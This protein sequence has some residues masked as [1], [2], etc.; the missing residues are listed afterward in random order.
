VH[1]LGGK[2]GLGRR[3]VL[4]S[5][6][7]ARATLDRSGVVEILAHGHAQA[8][9]G[10]VEVEGLV[11]PGAAM[12]DQGVLACNAQI[13]RAV[14]HVGRRVGGAHDDQGTSSRL[15]PMMSLREVSGLSVG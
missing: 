6:T 1:A 3:N 11:E 2:V 10:D 4:G 12:L 13:G 5:H 8:A 7:D 15:V 9:L 14:L